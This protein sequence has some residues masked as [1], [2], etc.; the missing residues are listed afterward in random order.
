SS[1]HLDV[2]RGTPHR[3]IGAAAVDEGEESKFRRQLRASRYL[4]SAFPA[5]PSRVDSAWVRVSG[6]AIRRSTRFPRV[7]GSNPVVRF[8]KAP[9]R[10]VF[11]GVRSLFTGMHVPSRGPDG[12]G[13]L[14]RCPNRPRPLTTGSRV[15]GCGAARIRTVRTAGARPLDMTWSSRMMRSPGEITGTCAL[16]R[17]PN[18]KGVHGSVSWPHG[19]GFKGTKP[20]PLLN[21]R[22]V[23]RVGRHPC[24]PTVRRFN[25]LDQV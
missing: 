1:P 22:T 18:M 17:M 4:C 24:R 10:R 2:R 12:E 7:A 20:A 3:R 25:Y 9:L 15:C 6:L 16:R 23:G 8:E 21:R 14:H 5:F 19:F 11:V 13:Q